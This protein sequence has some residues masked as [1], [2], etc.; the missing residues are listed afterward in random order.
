MDQ[1]PLPAR[2][3]SLGTDLTI[4][5]VV[6][7]LLLGAFGAGAIALYREIYSPAAFVERYLSLLSDA[8]AAD[9]L[10]VPG[11]AVD[12]DQLLALGLDS[13]P[14]E[15]LLRSA[16]LGDL[17]EIEVIE[18]TLGEDGV[19]RVRAQYLAGGHPGTSTFRV[20]QDGWNGVVPRWRFAESPL[21]VIDLVIRG[22]DEVTVNGFTFD[23][24][25]VAPEGIDADPLMPVSLLVLT[26]GIYSLSVDTAVSHTPGVRVLTDSPRRITPVDLQTEPTEEFVRVVQEQVEDFLEQK[27]ATQNVLM[28][29]ACPFGFTVQ[30][31]LASEPQWAIAQHPMI[32]VVP[33][34]AHW[35]I[36]PTEAIAHVEVDVRSLFDGSVQTVDE[37]VPF[38]ING[39]VTLLADG[40]LS[41]KIGSP[42]D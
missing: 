21:A 27:C 25:Q 29:T 17:S 9:A 14:S 13:T 6:G 34:G 15:A 4:I 35:Q 16:A 3:R 8:R 36:P 1:T 32:E 22:S 7:M 40:S 33:D 11:V 23:R 18:E 10:R 28:P 26:P 41:I 5:T 24:R 19:T 31:Q 39:T 42:D 30:H 38:R 20:V 37:D 2:R 12:R